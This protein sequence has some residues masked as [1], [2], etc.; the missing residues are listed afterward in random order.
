MAGFGSGDIS[1]QFVPDRAASEAEAP[2]FWEGSSGSEGASAAASHTQ[3]EVR[4]IDPGRWPEVDLAAIPSGMRPGERSGARRLM[5]AIDAAQAF[6]RW[7]L[8]VC[9]PS[10]P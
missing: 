5:G 10:R 2:R 9:P 7:N 3:A 6:R 1:V 4:H 8:G